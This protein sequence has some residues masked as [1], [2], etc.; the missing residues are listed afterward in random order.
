MV[1]NKIIV[2]GKKTQN[3]GYRLRLL[4]Q[5]SEFG[6]SHLNVKNIDELDE[7]HKQIVEIFV[8]NESNSIIEFV[9]DI[10]KKSNYPKNAIVD[11]IEII[12]KD[13]KGNIMTIESFSM[14][15][16]NSQLYKM[17]EVGSVMIE[18]QEETIGEIKS[19][20]GDFKSYFDLGKKSTISFL[21]E[22]YGKIKS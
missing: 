9:N 22:R 14:L 13:Y 7:N 12:D 10:M 18:K 19:L 15:L 20:R 17:T 2:K 4:G 11:S 8:G 21:S 5:A 3:V 6:I 16:T 1:K